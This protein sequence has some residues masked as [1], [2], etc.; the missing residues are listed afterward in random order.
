MKSVTL[1]LIIVSSLFVFNCKENDPELIKPTVGSTSVA[2]VGPSS[3]LLSATVTDEGSLSVTSRGI[4]YSTSATPTIETASKAISGS[5]E[6]SFEVELTNL[7]P[8]TTYFARAYATSDI[9]T[10]YGT[11]VD[12]TTQI[13]DITPPTVTNISPSDGS[14]DVDRNTNVVVEFSEDIDAASID[15]ITFIL[16]DTDAGSAITSTRLV[17]GNTVTLT[18]SSSLEFGKNYTFFAREEIKDLAGNQ[19][20]ADYKLSF[21]TFDP[22]LPAIFLKEW[23]AL[24]ATLSYEI[25]EESKGNYKIKD[26][27]IGQTYTFTLDDITVDNSGSHP[28]YI[29]NSLDAW[30]NP[31]KTWNLKME[32]NENELIVNSVVEYFVVARLMSKVYYNGGSFTANTYPNWTEN[33]NDGTFNFTKS[34]EHDWAIY[35]DKNDGSAVIELNLYDMAVYYTPTG[36]SRIKLYDITGMEN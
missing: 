16:F 9:G 11:E 2:N 28:V 36:G 5:G 29:C 18:P 33:N 35:L 32:S 34:G 3:A 25:T 4:V 30:G 7:T 31:S 20:A 24:D 21:T 26:G 22:S 19:L 8:E 13:L 15:H 14:I 1:S 12:F 27:Y 10:A 23:H 6:G 17:S